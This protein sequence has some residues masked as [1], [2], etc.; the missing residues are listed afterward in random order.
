[1]CVCMHVCVCVCMSVGVGSSDCSQTLPKRKL[2]VLG[3]CNYMP[4][5]PLTPPLLS[6]DLPPP[7]PPSTP[8][9][10][11]FVVSKGRSLSVH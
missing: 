4:L 2:Y 8:P 5:L 11:M 1:M 9:M 3:S 6:P 10:H 7:L